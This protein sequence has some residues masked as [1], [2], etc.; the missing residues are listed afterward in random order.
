MHHDV[1]PHDE[2]WVK[3]GGDKGGSSF[4][5]T[6][7]IVNVSHP[8]S[9]RNTVVFACFCADDSYINLKK[10]LPQVLHQLN[11]LAKLKWQ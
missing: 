9:L 7:Q 11:D 6:Y 8:N 1:I 5:M 4:K 3:F 10:T 2:I